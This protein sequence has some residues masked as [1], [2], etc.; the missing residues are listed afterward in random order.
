MPAELPG[1]AEAGGAGGAVRGGER[2]GALAGTRPGPGPVRGPA[3]GPPPLPAPPPRGPRSLPACTN[4]LQQLLPSL[5]PIYRNS[6]FRE[7]SYPPKAGGTKEKKNRQTSYQS[8]A[9]ALSMPFPG[10]L[11]AARGA[12]EAPVQSTTF[13]QGAGLQPSRSPRAGDR[14]RRGPGALLA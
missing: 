9:Q 5:S 2:S 14:R 4:A 11:S 6:A 13:L 8:P 1:G 12:G 3:A 10:G 7:I